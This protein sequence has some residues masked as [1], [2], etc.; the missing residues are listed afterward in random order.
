MCAV[1]C[2]IW[3]VVAYVQSLCSRRLRHNVC[4]SQ[5]VNI[6]TKTTLHTTTLKSRIHHQR[7]LPGRAQHMNTGHQLSIESCWRSIIVCRIR[8][9]LRES[10][11]RIHSFRIWSGSN[12][13][14]FI[15]L[16][17]CGAFV[18]AIVGWRYVQRASYLY[19]TILLIHTHTLETFIYWRPYFI[20]RH[21]H[22]RWGC[23]GVSLWWTLMSGV[24]YDGH[25][26][27]HIPVVEIQRI[28][29]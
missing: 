7:A 25:T 10:R 27:E 3:T 4:A 9:K 28:S 29:E 18:V 5:P 15:H 19:I 12:P 14:H 13:L 17:A 1:L 20:I 2:T 6:Q 26:T 23:F 22:H 16:C 11:A 21:R 24:N 8:R